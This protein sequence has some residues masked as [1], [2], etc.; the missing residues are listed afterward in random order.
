MTENILTVAARV[1]AK[2]EAQE[3]VKSELLKL[4]RLTHE[5]PGCVQFDLH[6]ASDD[7]CQ[8]RINEIWASQKDL[9][10]HLDKPYLNAFLE[11]ADVLLVAPPDISFWKMI[12][13]PK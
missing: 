10:Q 5:E 1:Q 8:F 6:Q 9:D 7:A 2:P 11:K 12:S 4:V 13:T 3:Q